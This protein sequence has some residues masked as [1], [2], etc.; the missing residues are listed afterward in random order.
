MMR[1][2]NI[3]ADGG[4]GK[5]S[6]T[7][8]TCKKVPLR[9]RDCQPSCVEGVCRSKGEGCGEVGEQWRREQQSTG[10]CERSI[11]PRTLT[12]YRDESGQTQHILCHKCLIKFLEQE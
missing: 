4:E 8:V 12:F 2:I 9:D 11:P 5:C 3:R 6:L 10:T 7:K 1:R